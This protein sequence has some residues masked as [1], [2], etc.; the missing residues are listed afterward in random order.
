MAQ[1]LGST[2]SG[3][4]EYAEDNSDNR[5]IYPTRD[6]TTL[7]SGKALGVPFWAGGLQYVYE[8]GGT[9]G[10]DVGVS[11][12]SPFGAANVGHFGFGNATTSSARST[13]VQAAGDWC[14]ASGVEE[15]ELPN[16]KY[17][18]GTQ[19]AWAGNNALRQKLNL[20]CKGKCVLISEVTG[21]VDGQNT[22]GY[23]FHL[24]GVRHS[25]WTGF[26]I[27][28]A[29]TSDVTTAGRGGVVCTCRAASFYGNS[30]EGVRFV[31]GD[32]SGDVNALRADGQR[33]SM[34][35]IGN[36]AAAL[37]TGY[38][39]YFNFINRC[40]FNI[41]YTH[42]L[43]V[44]GDGAA[45]TN[46]PNRISVGDDNIFERYIKCVD[47]GDADEA[48]VGHSQFH[49][50]AGLA[51]ANGG[52]T[53]AV[54]FDGAYLRMGFS[55]E[56]GANARPF[57]L[58]VNATNVEDFSEKNGSQGY[59]DPAN[60][61][62]R[63]TGSD[64]GDYYGF[65]RLNFTQAQDIDIFG[66]GSVGHAGGNTQL[67]V[68]RG[69]GSADHLEVGHDASTN[70]AIVRANGRNLDLRPTSDSHNVIVADSTWSASLMRLGNYRFWVN[71]SGK[72]MMKF[73]EPTSD[74]D[75]TVVGT[76]A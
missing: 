75:G 60:T 76:Q 11:D 17:T 53:D 51:G 16:G 69:G 1:G 32:P 64:I 2:G 24:D 50:S 49:Q 33:V 25:E 7:A 14:L 38:A 21:D 18:L 55:I 28:Y 5:Y 63:I 22:D 52:Y 70:D 30:F 44:T 72:L 58:G 68:W 66:N 71:G 37:S 20:I 42:V 27:D 23:L 57:A 67:R 41:A 6:A 39:C 29:V 45:A 48:H 9:A 43:A 12:I 56:A 35:F 13:A 4:P 65:R 59:I 36:E 15:L 34:K 26:T 74:A 47:F 54:V 62:V 19:I 61:S 46:Q 73:G 10:D 40:S 8:L 3:Y 31:G